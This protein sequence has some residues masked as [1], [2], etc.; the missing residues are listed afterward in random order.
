MRRY[1]VLPLTTF[2]VLFFLLLTQMV[3]PVLAATYTYNWSA[4]IRGTPDNDFYLN[5]S[6]AIDSDNNIYTTGTFYGTVDFD[7]TAGTDNVVANVSGSGYVSK[8]TETK[9]YVWTKNIGTNIFPKTIFT[10]SADNLLIHGVGNGTV[11]FD[12][13]PGTQNRNVN[14]G[15]FTLKLDQDGN[16]VWVYVGT[17]TVTS[18]FITTTFGEVDS[19]D[20]IVEATEVFDNDTFVTNT[21]VSR[22]NSS[23]SLIW[24]FDLVPEDEFSNV[25]AEG[26]NCNIRG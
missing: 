20:N 6:A 14:G 18:P 1:T 9:A 12:P 23:G 3:A 11:D 7:P 4:V 26:V 13:G 24:T 22:V 2:V 8:V 25:R 15:P 17:L 16:F 21:T 10:D 19:G 5:Q